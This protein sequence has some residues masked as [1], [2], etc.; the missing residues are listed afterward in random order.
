MS[1]PV[2]TTMEPLRVSFG[3]EP[4]PANITRSRPPDT[5]CMKTA[6]GMPA[7]WALWDTSAGGMTA[8][9]GTTCS[10]TSSPCWSKRPFSLAMNS[11][12]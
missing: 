4:T 9:F 2:R 8:L 11:A 6:S 1:M 12:A 5:A 7:I 3:V 10:V